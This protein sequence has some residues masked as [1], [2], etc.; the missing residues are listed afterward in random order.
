[1]DLEENFKLRSLKKIFNHIKKNDVIVA[2]SCKTLFKLEL[3][4]KLKWDEEYESWM[5]PKY[6]TN[7][8]QPL[9]F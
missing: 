1:M 8:I 2:D 4:L 3:A 9:Q 5:A 7:F 6:D